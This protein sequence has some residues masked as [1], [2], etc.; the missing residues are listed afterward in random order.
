MNTAGP[1][2]ARAPH[3][4]GRDGPHQP[5]GGAMLRWAVIFL[6]VAIVAALLGFM[7]IAWLSK[8]IAWILAVVFIILFIV[9]LVLGRRPPL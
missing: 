9:S 4:G 7:E 8:E 3:V 2:T 5:E 1:E 6:V